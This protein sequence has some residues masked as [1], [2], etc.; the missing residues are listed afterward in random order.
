MNLKPGR[1]K[2]MVEDA[3]RDDSAVICHET[4]DLSEQAVCRGFHEAHATSPL[5]IAERLGMIEEVEL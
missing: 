4:Y 2:G 5:Q 1:V 3:V